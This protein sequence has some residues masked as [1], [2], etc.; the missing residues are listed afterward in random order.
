MVKVNYDTRSDLLQMTCW[1]QINLRMSDRV[2]N[3]VLWGFFRR[4]SADTGKETA[5]PI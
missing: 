5:D 4:K 1:I 3:D 2:L